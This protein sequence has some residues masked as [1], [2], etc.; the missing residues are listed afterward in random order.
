MALVKGTN[1]YVD[2]AEADAYFA[3]RIDADLWVDTDPLR[4]EQSLISAT[5]VLDQNSWTGSV[6]SVTQPL[7]FP[8]IGSYFDPKIGGQV[9]LEGVP[10]RVKQACYEQAFHMLTN[11]GVLDSTGTVQNL[12]V[13]SIVLDTIINPGKQSPVVNTLIR[14]LLVNG[15]ARLWWRAN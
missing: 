12:R 2:V 9:I 8:R 15:G 4:K 11:E 5:A 6:V 14:P 1:S 13:G 10:E 7:A 3:N